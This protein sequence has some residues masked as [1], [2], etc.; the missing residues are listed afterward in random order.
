MPLPEGNLTRAQHEIMEV[1]WSAGRPGATVASI[2]DAVSK[3]RPVART[4]VLNLVDRLEKR[5]WLKRRQHNGAFHYKA[6]VSRKK[7]AALLTGEFV[8]GFFGG[9][10]TDLVMSLLG[11]KQLKPEEIDQLRQLLDADA[12]DE[13]ERHAKREN[14]TS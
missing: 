3:T 12:N 7:T 6:T 5:G 4:T 10:A 8:D 14:E 9:S 11:S 13:D 2:W 1:V